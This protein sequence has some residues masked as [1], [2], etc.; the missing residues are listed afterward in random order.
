[1]Q[2]DALVAGF[3]EHRQGDQGA[4]LNRCL[5]LYEPDSTTQIPIDMMRHGWSM[6]L[7]HASQ[8]WSTM[9]LNDFK[10]RFE[11]LI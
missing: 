3:L 8:Q 10:T 11:S 2:V 4:V 7:F 6:S 1:M 5:R 9:S